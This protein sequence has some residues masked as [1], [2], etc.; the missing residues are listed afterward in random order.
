MMSCF[1]LRMFQRNFKPI[2]SDSHAT[3]LVQRG[4]RTDRVLLR[5]EVSK[6]SKYIDP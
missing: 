5:P 3:R 6:K 4:S 2:A 1:M